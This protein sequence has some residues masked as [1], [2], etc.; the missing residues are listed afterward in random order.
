M[1]LADDIASL[2]EHFF[3]R[4]FT[5]SQATFRPKPGRE[6]ELADALLLIGQSVVAYQLKEREPVASAT[7]ATELQWFE[8][9][10]L[11]KATRQIRDTLA[12]LHEHDTIRLKNHHG[13]EVVLQTPQLR[14]I[15]KLVVYL[16]NEQLPH[17]CRR[18]KH[19]RSRTA[20]VI[21][22]ISSNDYFGIVTTLLTPAELMDYLDYRAALITR[23][24]K[25]VEE[26]PEP[27][28]V[29]HYLRGNL[30]EIPDSKHLEYL[31]RLTHET[32]KWDMSGI[33]SVFADRITSGGE[34]TNYYPIISAIAELK[35]HELAEFKLR[36]T[37][38]IEKAK[39][40]EFVL[41]YR[42]AIPRTGC[43]F[44]F[45]PLT[46]KFIPQRGDALRYITT[47]HKYDQ[48]LPRC[49]GVSV[50]PDADGWYF[51]EW[52]YLEYPWKNDPELDRLLTANKPFREV[53]V[54]KADRYS[55][56]R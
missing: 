46:L 6:F 11:R 2:N 19:H 52:C 31:K 24:P 30:D 25:E 3:F 23:W 45:I 38:A 15:H 9:K 34:M 42:M 53:R 44:I 4:E 37:L 1:K 39:A 41:P 13:H 33:I 35:R 5:Y 21:H 32:Q 48:K 27:V 51:V 56:R 17:Q 26:V 7:S 40:N 20:D 47:A 22:L 12:Y 28:L 50:A 10:V 54:A 49:V 55:F 14:I 29:G 18:R 43:G 8:R 36:F 16:P